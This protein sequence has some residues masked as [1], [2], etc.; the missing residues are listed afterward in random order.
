MH[1]RSCKSVL[2]VLQKHL[3]IKTNKKNIKKLKG[4]SRAQSK[5]IIIKS[6][7]N[8]GFSNKMID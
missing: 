3:N 2:R 6:I 7:K 1:E 4:K 8:I 5:K